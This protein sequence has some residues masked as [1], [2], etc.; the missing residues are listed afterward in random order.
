MLITFEG[1]DGSGKTTQARKLFEYLKEK[2][3][4]AHLFREPGGTELAEKLRKVIL[5]SEL[6]PRSELLLFE[7]SRV[8]LISRRVKP[9]LDK[10][11]TVIIDRFTD[12]TV[13]YQGYGRGLD[14]D[15]IKSLNDFATSGI[16]PSLTILL[17]VEPEVALGRLK[18]KTRFE[19]P[20]F[21][22]R[23]RLGFLKIAQEEP[24]RV[25]VVK[26]D[27][28]IK[29]VWNRVKEIFESRFF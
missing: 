9:L 18:G 11:D 2:G 16:K 12:S 15:F 1:I 14:I 13:A 7:A 25:F 27:A 23:V 4:Q 26:A 6:D 20:D 17:D 8:D 28:P 22:R 21:L 29:E 10:G 3:I 19:E 24:Q 5:H